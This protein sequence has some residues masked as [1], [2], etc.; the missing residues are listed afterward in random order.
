VVSTI[1]PVACLDLQ[2]IGYQY[3]SLTGAYALQEYAVQ[4]GEYTFSVLL[5]PVLPSKDHTPPEAA[6][7]L[8]RQQFK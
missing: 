8:W 5:A 7:S 1:K 2:L 4:P 3:H 6:A